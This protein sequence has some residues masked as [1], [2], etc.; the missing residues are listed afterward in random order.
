VPTSILGSSAPAGNRF[1]REVISVAVR[2]YLR[3]GLSYR[4]AEELLAERGNEIDHVT[5]HRRMRVCT[6]AKCSNRPLPRGPAHRI[7]FAGGLACTSRRPHV[8]SILAV[9]HQIRGETVI[10]AH[11]Q[12]PVRVCSGWS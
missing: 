8:G 6:V 2:W 4:D 7:R 12:H 11:Q 5:I 9:G 3:Y 1:P 10:A